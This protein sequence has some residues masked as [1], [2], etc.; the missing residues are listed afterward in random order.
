M[1]RQSSPVLN[2]REMFRFHFFHAGRAL[3]CLLHSVPLL[4]YF[5]RW[6]DVCTKMVRALVPA[7]GPWDRV[8]L[9]LISFF[10]SGAYYAQGPLFY[11][12]SYQTETLFV[13]D[14]IS[15]ALV[16]SHFDTYPFIRLR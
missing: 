4:S 15:I 16:E 9:I 11:T 6:F 1:G 5:Y 14:A 13:L 10:M 8:I 12:K 2:S 3:F 7:G